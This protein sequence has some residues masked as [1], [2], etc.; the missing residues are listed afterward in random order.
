MCNSDR[1]F[2][3]FFGEKVRCETCS[4]LDGGSRAQRGLEQ[5]FGARKS[6]WNPE[7]HPRRSRSAR[8]HVRGCAAAAAQQARASR[9]TSARGRYL[10]PL[11]RHLR[12]PNFGKHAATRSCRWD[13]GGEDAEEMGLDFWLSDCGRIDPGG[14]F[15]FY[16]ETFGV[17]A[18]KWQE[19]EVKS[20]GW[21]R[22]LTDDAGSLI[23]FFI[24]RL[25]DG[26][27][28]IWLTRGQYCRWPGWF[29][30]LLEKCGTRSNII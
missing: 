22:Y 1:N 29:E 28:G 2:L 13:R 15:F 30:I 10:L 4:Y 6:R 3:A 8:A 19:Q 9:S 23:Q 17:N 21:W 18:G 7:S 16:P 11:R 14:E 25:A 26:T 5:A 20:W 12:P 24:L 27:S